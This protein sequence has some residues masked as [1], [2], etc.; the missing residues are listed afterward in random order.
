MNLLDAERLLTRVGQHMW[1]E[2][3]RERKAGSA[4]LDELDALEQAIEQVWDLKRG[5]RR[6]LYKSR[7]G[8]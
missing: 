5:V 2:Y 4:S 6:E 1:R 7:H 8:E 3:W